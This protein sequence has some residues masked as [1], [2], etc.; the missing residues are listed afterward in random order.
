[1]TGV[2]TCAL[3]ISEDVP[4]ASWAAVSCSGQECPGARECDDGPQCFAE[5]ARALAAD[6]DVIIVNHALA[7]LDIGAD[8]NVL[9][10]HDL[11]VVDEAHALAEA[12]DFARAAALIDSLSR[13]F[14][15]LPYS[16]VS[17]VIDGWRKNLTD[18]EDK[19]AKLRAQV[20]APWRAPFGQPWKVPA[21]QAQEEEK[22]QQF[23]DYLTKFHIGL[24]AWKNSD[25]ARDGHSL[26]KRLTAQ[27]DGL[28]AT[29]REHC[30][31]ARTRAIGVRATRLRS[32]TPRETM[33][34]DRR[35]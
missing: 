18:V 8:G 35:R 20:E 23:H 14:T 29:L 3:P 31:A 24:E 10:D 17:E 30:D 4:D 32:L 1:M 11:L 19:F 22:L 7:C 5:R 13:V 26:F 28:R 9:P 12:G 16:Q 27:V 34:S 15:D 33:W 6:A 21:H 2:Q 25:F